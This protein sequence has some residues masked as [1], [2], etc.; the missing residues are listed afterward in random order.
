MSEE[1]NKGKPASDKEVGT[2]KAEEV[3]AINK[4]IQE[5]QDVKIKEM[6][7][8][9]EKKF[10]TQFENLAEQNNNY[11]EQIE[12]VNKKLEESTTKIAE[13]EEKFEGVDKKIEE[14]VP[15]KG[16]A[17]TDDG[18]PYKGISDE[19]KAKQNSDNPSGSGT[20]VPVDFKESMSELSNDKVKDHEMGK[21]FIDS[22]RN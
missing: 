18:N 20:Q 19:E 21:A 22:I 2:V 15:R 16:L 11:K 14:L 4:E 3:E 8:G 7:D 1:D 6:Q 13:Y 12:A 17:N 9:L 5:K 10:N